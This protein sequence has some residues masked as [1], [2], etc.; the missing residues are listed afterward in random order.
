MTRVITVN[1]HSLNVVTMQNALVLWGKR[2]F[3]TFPWRLT[4]DPYKVLISEIM[5]HRTQALQV[6][7]VFDQ[8]INAYPNIS[9]LAQ[10]KKEDLYR[11]LYSLGL[12]WRADLL[13]EMIDIIIS[14]YYGQIPTAKDDLLSLPGVST[15]IASAVRCFAWNY[16]E[17]I[18]DTNT[19][20]IIGRLFGLE[21]KDS[22]RRNRQ[23]QDLNALLL[24]KTEPRAYN[25]ALLDLANKLCLKKQPPKCME[26]PLLLECHY[27]SQNLVNAY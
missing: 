25:F 4:H 13:I 17:P 12:K 7:S 9:S 27:G 19:V 8:F 23:F 11:I 21:I 14:R 1:K 22:S 15:Y 24:D 20:R 6:V 18:L 2:N 3:R 16:P 26:C 5:L 10:A